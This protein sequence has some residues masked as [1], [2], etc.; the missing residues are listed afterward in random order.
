MKIQ[1]FKNDRS[2]LH[3]YIT[4]N[5]KNNTYTYNIRKIGV[6]LWE[7]EE[8]GQRGTKSYLI[9]YCKKELRKDIEYIKNK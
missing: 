9:D 1:V 5:Y 6:R 2:N 4:C 8:N 7:V 3:S